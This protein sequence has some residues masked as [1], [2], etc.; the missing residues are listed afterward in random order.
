MSG[1]LAATIS[2]SDS[3][4]LIATS[5]FSKN[6]F[7]GVLRKHASDKEVMLV[8][9]GIMLSIAIIGILIA[10]DENSIIFNV[11]SFAWAGFGATFGPIMLFSLF[12]KR[13]TRN[14]ALAGMVSGGAVVFI[15]KLLVKPAGGFWGMY[16]LLPAFLISCYRDRD[17]LLVIKRTRAGDQGRI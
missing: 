3:Y 6:I 15:W 2:S 5:A 8:S 10:L 16:E 7:Q 13:T 4:L 14:G 12:W 11:V 17:H 9:R 1:I